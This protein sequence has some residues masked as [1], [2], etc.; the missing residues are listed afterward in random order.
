M[1]HFMWQTVMGLCLLVI[2]AFLSW[3]T[4]SLEPSREAGEAVMGPGGTQGGA[5]TAGTKKFLVAIDPGHGGRDP[6][7]VSA[8]GQLEKDINLEIALKLKEYLEFSDVEVLLTREEDIG[9][10]TDQDS[11]KKMADMEMRCKLINDAKPDL[12]ISIHQNSYHEESVAG[13]Q[14]F[15]YSRSE[16]GKELAGILQRRFDYV[17]G[18]G[19]RRLEKA[20]DSYYLLLHVKSP[21]VIVE[22]GF[23]SNPAEAKEL[24]SPEY[25]DRMAWTLHMGIMEF[26]NSL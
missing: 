5:G 20:N 9:L 17:M 7:K 8:G 3:H 1:K 23:L 18:A 24:E 12:V 11:H 14:V 4:G 2:M 25:Q 19:N 21:I 15:Y 13:G 22:C 10:Y 26:L 16:K 6:G